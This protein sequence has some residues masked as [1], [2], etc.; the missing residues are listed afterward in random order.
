[1]PHGGRALLARHRSAHGRCALGPRVDRAKRASRL[2]RVRAGATRGVGGARGP[3][4]PQGRSCSWAPPGSL[5]PH[6]GRHILAR[7]MDRHACGARCRP[8]TS[9]PH[10][11]RRQRPRTHRPRTSLHPLTGMRAEKDTDRHG[12]A[13]LRYLKYKVTEPDQVRTPVALAFRQTVRFL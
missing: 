6:L 4:D 12:V 11:F 9:P 13:D 8:S 1:L 3:C 2:D 7:L 10:T 5:T